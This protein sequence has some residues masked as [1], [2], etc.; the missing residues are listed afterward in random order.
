MKALPTISIVTCTYNTDL[1]IFKKCLEAI[2]MQEYPKRKIEHLVMDA[3]STNGTIELAKQ[4]RCTVIVRKDLLPRE[5]VRQSIGFKK[6]KGDILLILE[7]DNILI[8]RN[9]LRKMVQP[10]M[11]DK[12]VVGTFSAYNGYEKNMS[13]LTRYTAFFGSP[14]PILYYLGKSD[15]IPVTQKRYD[16]GTLLKETKEYY[17]VQFTPQNLP[18]CG[19]NGHMVLRRAMS[20]VN[21]DSYSYVHLDALLELVELGYIK[22]GV[23]KNSII[24]VGKNSLIQD[25][26]RKIQ[27]KHEYYDK[28]RG[29][30]KYF[31]FN[32]SS[33]R[34]R[35]NLLKYIFFTLTFVEPLTESIRGYMKIRDSA[36]FVHPV[37]CFL[38]L[39]GH[40]YSEGRWVLKKIL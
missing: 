39:V 3:G 16:K 36:W 8:G 35:I 30:K 28:K 10:F 37:F 7:S 38:M 19:D 11:D 2:K 18:T 32:W 23:V 33:G 13:P 6:A 9:W 12:T 40:V 31:T 15:K 24:H 1:S 21:K 20:R 4:Y 17:A 29:M 27:L 25:V 34:D 14:H 22:F 5:E 26:R